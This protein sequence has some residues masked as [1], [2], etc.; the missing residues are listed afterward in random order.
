MS[1]LSLRVTRRIGM[2]HYKHIAHA[3]LNLSAKRGRRLRRNA[4]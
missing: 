1:R 4:S 2:N 3:D